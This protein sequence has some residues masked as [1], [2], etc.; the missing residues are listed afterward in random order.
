MCASELFIIGK[1]YEGI[2]PFLVC[3]FRD[4]DTGI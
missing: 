4:R 3:V 1:V 2:L